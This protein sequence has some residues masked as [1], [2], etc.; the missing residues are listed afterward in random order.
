MNES[1]RHFLVIQFTEVE[2]M[3]AFTLVTIDY[4]G[5]EIMD[6]AQ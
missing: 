1:I 2:E 4:E 5:I 6:Y 3:L